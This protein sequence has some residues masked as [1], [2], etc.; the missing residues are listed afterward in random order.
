[1]AFFEDEI[2]KDLEVG[3]TYTEREI[4]SILYFKDNTMV[5]CEDTKH[6]KSDNTVS[7]YKVLER[8]EAYIHEKRNN[9]V[10]PNGTTIVYWVMKVR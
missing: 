9:Y 10:I 8:T 7:K 3:N 2:I 1:M 6:F 4:S 5:I